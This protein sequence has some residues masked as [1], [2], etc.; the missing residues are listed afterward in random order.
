M[1]NINNYAAEKYAEPN[2][3]KYN[4]GNTRDNAAAQAIL[5]ARAK[6]L[7]ILPLMRASN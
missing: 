3:L 4:E 1:K 2:D 6:M 7:W 5:T